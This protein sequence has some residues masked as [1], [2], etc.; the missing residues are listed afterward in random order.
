VSY[1]KEL[2]LL[3]RAIDRNLGRIPTYSA[4]KHRKVNSSHY[5]RKGFQSS[6]FQS[7]SSEI[8]LNLSHC[9][10]RQRHLEPNLSPPLHLTPFDYSSDC[11]RVSFNMLS[12]FTSQLGN[13]SGFI[14]NKQPKESTT[15]GSDNPDGG[16][17]TVG[18]V[19]ATG[20]E[21]DSPSLGG[22]EPLPPQA[23]YMTNNKIL[24]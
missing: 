2:A 19:T 24:F 13:L 6:R 5:T 4:H 10:C 20:S 12:G 3:R 14:G 1:T 22:T 23:G 15:T 21:Q 7:S 17:D 9:D 16:S 11:N 8:T 18:L